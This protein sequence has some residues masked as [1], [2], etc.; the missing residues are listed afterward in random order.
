MLIDNPLIMAA[1]YLVAANVFTFALFAY[2]KWCAQN[3]RWRV[4]E[5][6]LLIWAAIGG[7]LGACLAMGIFH[8][9][10]LHLKFKFGVP[11]LLCLQIFLVACAALVYTNPENLIGKIFGG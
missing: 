7:A 8:H 5:S 6:T 11:I 10:T 1:V 3:D 9:K 2:D 4:R